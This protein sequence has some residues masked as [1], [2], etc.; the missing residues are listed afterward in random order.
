MTSVRE[1]SKLF[2]ETLSL[3]V[4]ETETCMQTALKFGSPM[5]SSTVTQKLRNFIA[6]TSRRLSTGTTCQSLAH[7]LRS[8]LL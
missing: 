6:P 8:H 2:S 5:T 3:Y 1:P 4:W 7:H